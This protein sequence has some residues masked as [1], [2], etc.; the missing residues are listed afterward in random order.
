MENKTELVKQIIEC[1]G[2][3]NIISLS[4]CVSRLRFKLKDNGSVDE[5]RLKSLD[6]V[7]GVQISGEQ[8]QVI[9]GLQVEELYEEIRKQIGLN[10]DKEEKKDHW[11]W[12]DILVKIPEA[13]VASVVPVLPII[14]VYGLFNLVILILSALPFFGSESTTVKIFSIVADACMT[15]LPVF[16]AYAASRHFHT[17]TVLALLLGLSITAPDFL[18]L[19][20]T[21]EKIILFGL[22]VIP[23]DYS[24]SIIPALLATAVLSVVEGF[25]KKHIRGNAVMLFVPFLTMLVMVPLTFVC[26]APIGSLLNDA[27]SSLMY[28]LKRILGPFATGILAAVYNPLILTGMHHTLAIVGLAEYTQ[29]GFES[30]VYVGA[31][32]QVL[33]TLGAALSFALKAKKP[34]NRKLGRS[35]FIINTF[36]G[37]TE[38]TLYGVLVPHK[39]VFLAQLI[40]AFAGGLY[41]GTMNVKAY[42]IVTAGILCL[43][44][45]LSGGVLNIIHGLIGCAIAFVVSFILVRIFGFDEDSSEELENPLNKYL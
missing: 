25:F 45:F 2:K 21:G 16:V 1:V 22:P 8:Y 19:I 31:C 33:S 3:D 43:A 13:L 6:G 9:V 44:N 32:A 23:N 5:N 26:L 12:K 17:S 39:K 27:V 42:T 40:G 37:L 18:S 28:L 41:L 24:N 4:H 30:F 36:P 34:E 29:N 35:T 38:P 15:F 14:I 7:K 20:G 11:T 10:E